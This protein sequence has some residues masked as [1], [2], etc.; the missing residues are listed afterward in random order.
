[1]VNLLPRIDVRIHGEVREFM[2]R[3]AELARK[4]MKYRVEVKYNCDHCPEMQAVN[5]VPLFNTPHTGLFGQFVYFSKYKS[6]MHVEV[7]AMRWSMAE[8][9]RDALRPTY[10][11]YVEAARQMFDGLV[12]SYNR[13]HHTKRRLNIQP[14]ETMEPIL[15]PGAQKVFEHFALRANKSDLHPLDWNRFYMFVRYCHT[16]RVVLGEESL[17]RI[18]VRSGF[19]EN[20]GWEIAGAYRHIRAF[21]KAPKNWRWSL[22]A[23]L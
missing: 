1:M 6:R 23:R 2:D 7:A 13:I 8:P 19:A 15:P 11:T 10:E 20:D 21:L 9:A 22:R 16:R 4:S 3:F 17:C 5:F 14:R 18:L 12:R